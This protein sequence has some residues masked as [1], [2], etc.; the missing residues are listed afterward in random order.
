MQ[1]QEDLM[2]LMNE[3]KI[4]QPLEQMLI[5]VDDDIKELILGLLKYDPEERMSIK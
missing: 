4:E 2:N 3:P 1:Q 5:G